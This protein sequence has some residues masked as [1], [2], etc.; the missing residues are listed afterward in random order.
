M[1]IL[2]L[3]SAQVLIVLITVPEMQTVRTNGS[4]RYSLHPTTT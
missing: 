2:A 4:D 1:N 3:Q